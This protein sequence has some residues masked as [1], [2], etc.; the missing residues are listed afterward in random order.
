MPDGRVD[1]KGEVRESDPPR[2]LVVT[3]T[4]EWIEPKLPECI[5]SYVIEPVGDAIWCA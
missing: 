4:V 1:V 3:W 5:V 2:K